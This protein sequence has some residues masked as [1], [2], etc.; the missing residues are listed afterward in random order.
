LRGAAALGFGHVC[1]SIT[2]DKAADLVV[3]PLTPSRRASWEAFL[4]SAVIPLAVYIA[5]T[6]RSGSFYC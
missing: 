3:V 1:G 5:G 4:D 6:R 2:P